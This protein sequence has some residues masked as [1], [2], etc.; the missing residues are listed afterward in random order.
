MIAEPSR[1]GHDD[2]SALAQL[3]HLAADRVAAV[4]RDAAQL[5]PL[6]EPGQFVVDLDG[7]LSGRAEHQGLH[8]SVAQIEFVR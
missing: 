2:V 3:L 7:Q 6:A 1:G 5:V 8:R 4:D